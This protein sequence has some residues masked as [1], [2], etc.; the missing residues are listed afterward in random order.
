MSVFSG[1]QGGISARSIESNGGI[2]RSP[3][4]A[5]AAVSD[6]LRLSDDPMVRNRRKAALLSLVNA[7][8]LGVVALYQFGLIRR[9]PE[10]PLPFLDA[11]RVDASS[12]AYAL[13]RTPDA[14]IG[15]LSA[16]ITLALLG[17]GARSRS[18]WLALATAGKVLADA[19]GAMLLSAEQASRH[20]KFCGWC[21][22][23]AAASVAAVPAVVP[24][25]LDAVR[26]LRDGGRR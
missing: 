1:T 5:A 25:T 23:A 15:I 21:L 17:R 26:R 18:P 8:A 12:E 14:A 6:A 22:M 19:G 3:S 20:R 10:P 4:D 7:G 24:E 9:V 11:D 13:G 2:G 16:G